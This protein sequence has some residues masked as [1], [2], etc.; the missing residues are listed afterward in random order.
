MLEVRLFG[1][2]EVRCDGQPVMISSRPAQ[3][4]FA[5]LILNAGTSYRREKLAGMFW[6]DATEQKARAYLRYEL[7]RIRKAF[8]PSASESLIADD[9][10]ISFDASVDYWLDVAAFTR[11]R[12]GESIKELTEALSLVHGEFLPAF[13]EEW[14]MHERDHLQ[15]DYEEKISCL[16]DL[17]ER[18]QRWREILKWAEAWISLGPAPEA[19]Y[20]ALMLAYDR[21]G[22][23]AKVASTYDR[24]VQA[25]REMDLEPSEETRAL[26]F[27]RASRHKIPIPL[28]SFVGRKEELKEVVALLATSRL[29]TLTGSGGVG[30]TRLSIEVASEVLGQFPDGIWFLDLAPLN[31]PALIPNTLGELVGLRESGETPL[32][33]LL[34]DHFRPRTALL[35]FDNCEHLIE[36]C[37]QLIHL[38]LASCRNLS[39]LAT[40]R[41]GLRISGEVPYR[42]PSLETPRP[43]MALDITE[44]SNMESVR[45]FAERAALSAPGFVL[46]SHN[47]PAVAQI[48][49]RLDGIPLAI[50]LAAARVKVLSV[51]QIVQRLNDR[52]HLLAGGLRSALPRHQTL[53]AT[54][55]WSYDLLS[56]QE[57]L[58]FRRLAVFTGDWTVESAEEVCAGHGIESSRVLDLLSQLVN[59]SLV[60]V[61]STSR[62]MSSDPRTSPLRYHMLETIRQYALEKLTKNREKKRVSARH[63]EYFLA[64]V[65]T[66]ESK[67]YGEEQVQWL[68]RLREEHEN[69]RSALEWADKADVEAG[70]LLSGSMQRFWENFQVFEG[71]YWQAKFLQ[72]PESHRYPRAR[73]RALC[74]YGWSLV[75]LQQY[76]AAHSRAEESLAV[77]RAVGD[78]AG[79]VDA[80][81]LLA[82]ISSAVTQ[83]RELIQRALELAESIGDVRRQSSA[84]WQLGWL[85]QGKE[86][87]A[88]WEKAI[89]LTRSLRNW[90]G[91]A[92][93]LSTAGF[94]LVLNGELE[95][96]QRYLDE[97]N[98]LYQQW[99]FSP[100]PAHLF[101]GYAQIA[102]IQGDFK[103]ARAYL[104]ESIRI[105]AEFGSRQAVLWA[106]V[107]LGYLALSEGN[108]P[109][110]RQCFDET[111]RSFREDHYAIGVTYALEGMA[112]LFVREEKFERAAALIGWA[113]ATRQAIGDPR[114]LLEKTYVESQITAVTSGIGEDAFFQAYR[115]GQGMTS[116]GALTLALEV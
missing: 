68:H 20:R 3:S 29:V 55:E 34:I 38:L 74:M 108:F 76:A 23:H 100:P 79:E 39:V 90:R 67:L 75:S 33:K 5:F 86:G 28:T 116:D 95:T 53:R 101:S 56:E 22:E 110:A 63:L 57:R 2:F 17:L 46:N 15:A 64:L 27:K 31:D 32:P 19:A 47:G 42:V 73:A 4:L 65:Q 43:G 109:E 18:Q 99:N 69:L 97:S 24:C 78:P 102:L 51:L 107:R 80:L 88:Y 9:I 59:K 49:E 36:A 106:R 111:A 113:D 8:H 35:L 115:S 71:S 11:V 114:P 81:L 44:L 26:A 41:E 112:G 104:A 12:A 62:R 58:L 14:V 13:Y 37:A 70:L 77:C 61:E 105:N 40:S 85:Y 87:L 92:G 93:S 45:L 7:W 89:A 98:R 84:L 96:A 54:I 91:L 50:E 10:S 48:C 60:I 25:L 30:K 72:K 83:K 66:A 6:P 16:I 94:F 1:T 103:K 21:L 52:F 82:W